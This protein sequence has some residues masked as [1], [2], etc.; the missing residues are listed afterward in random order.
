[1]LL[2]EH[3]P[4]FEIILLPNPTPVY[5]ERIVFRVKAQIGSRS[6]EGGNQDLDLGAVMVSG[7]QYSVEHLCLN[8]SKNL[9]AQQWRGTTA[10]ALTAGN[11]S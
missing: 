8:R 6:R 9:G 1:M 3:R 4:A 5:R 10:V 2:L 11:G 7:A